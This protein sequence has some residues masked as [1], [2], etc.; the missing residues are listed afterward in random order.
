MLYLVFASR[1]WFYF[2]F[3]VHLLNHCEKKVTISTGAS[4]KF[5][6]NNYTIFVS[7]RNQEAVIEKKVITRCFFIQKPPPNLQMLCASENVDLLCRR[8]CVWKRGLREIIWCLSVCRVCSQ[9]VFWSY[10]VW[11]ASKVIDPEF[12]EPTNQTQCK[13]H[14]VVK[15]YNT[16]DVHKL[17]L[18]AAWC[19]L[20]V[21]C[22]LV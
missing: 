15:Q 3:F 19:S 10:S 7:F 9:V 8:A 5:G 20:V 21:W 22:S 2:V 1:Y 6:S 18:E 11:F 17:H 14:F 12:L 16:Y 4:Q 13:E